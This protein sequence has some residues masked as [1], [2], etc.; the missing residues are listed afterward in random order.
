M[1]LFG[2]L[3]GI[4][5]AVIFSLQFFFRDER[6]LKISRFVFPAAVIL[7]L[8]LGGYT[9]YRQ[10]LLW[11]SSDVAKLLLPPHSNWNFFIY[12][13]FFNFFAG[14]ALS[15]L[16]ALGAFFSFRFSNRKM[17]ERFLYPEEPVLFATGIF[18]SGHP[19]WLVYLLLVFFIGLCY[20]ALRFFKNENYKVS[21][22]FLWLPA[23]V[24]AIIISKWLV[25]FFWYKALII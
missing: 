6:F 19:G 8:A 12:Y 1:V 21:F 20:S 18:L 11:Q 17:G 16:I 13:S 7:I 9:A 23:A 15:F 4:Y 3:V 14:Y 22:R 2:E 10:Y 24:L 5:L 25:G